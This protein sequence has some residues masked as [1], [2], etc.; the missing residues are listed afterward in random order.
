MDLSE[1][2]FAAGTLSADNKFFYVIFYKFLLQY[3]LPTLD[4]K[5]KL[6]LNIAAAPVNPSISISKDLK[7]LYMISNGILYQIDVSIFK[8]KKLMRITPQKLSK[9]KSSL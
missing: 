8:I 7:Y 1:I 2:Y 3:A 4:L 5:L 9:C 6:D